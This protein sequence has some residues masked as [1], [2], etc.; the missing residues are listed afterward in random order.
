DASDGRLR[1]GVE[2]IRLDLHPAEAGSE[3]VVEKQQLRFSVHGRA[4]DARVVGGPADVGG[5]PPKVEFCE[6][7]GADQFAVVGTTDEANRVGDTVVEAVVVPRPLGELGFGLTERGE[8]A[9]VPPA[10]DHR[11][12]DG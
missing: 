6:G 1:P 8:P 10:E 3:G 7:G 11:M 4:P 5:L 12:P 9:A 2:N